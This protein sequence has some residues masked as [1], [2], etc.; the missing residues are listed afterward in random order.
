[1]CQRQ[2]RD[3]HNKTVKECNDGSFERWLV[4]PF[5]GQALIGLGFVLATG[6]W[7]ACHRTRIRQLMR[8]RKDD[9]EMD[10]IPGVSHLSVEETPQGLGA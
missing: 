7:A 4:R 1:M 6:L 2:R 9:I 10:S 3:L 5:L 8:N